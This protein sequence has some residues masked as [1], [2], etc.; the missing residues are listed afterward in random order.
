MLAALHFCGHDHEEQVRFGHAVMTMIAHQTDRQWP[1]PG[2]SHAMRMGWHDL[3]FAHW[4]FAPESVARLLPEGI[5]L[6]TYD[7][8]AW[9]GVVPFR[10]TDVAP[11][12]V[13]AMPWVSAF[14]ELNV[15]TY[16]TCDGKPGV[17]FFSL[18][19]TNPLAVRVARK[20]FHLPYMDARQSIRLADDWYHYKSQRTHRNEPAAIFEAKYRPTGDIFNAQPDTLEYW[21]TAR[22]CLYVA[23][24]RGQIMRGEIDHPPW[25]LQR[26][27]LQIT[28][29]TLLDSLALKPDGEPHLLFSKAIHV[30]AWTNE[31]A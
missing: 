20:F 9:L 23:N 2:R 12:F 25:Q 18:D 3:L 13:P 16:V 14:P 19:A 31:L 11:R 4:T 17:W 21:L 28:S 29:N 15:R 7:G 24:A 1:L 8:R 22:Y 26:A 10:M 5:Q 6:D 27:E 30:K